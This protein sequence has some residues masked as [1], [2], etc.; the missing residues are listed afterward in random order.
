LPHAAAC[1]EQVL[2]THLPQSVL[3]NDGGGGAAA[4]V[5]SELGLLAADV[6]AAGAE[7]ADAEALGV[8]EPV[9]SAELAAEEV[10]AAGLSGGLDPPPHA[11]QASGAA[12]M[13]T[14][15]VIG[16]R[17]ARLMVFD[18]V[19]RSCKESKHEVWACRAGRVAAA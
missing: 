7:D 17:W 19:A 15:V 6:S 5:A 4:A 10:S 16:R 12:T 14:R 8:S 3:P 9:G 18:C 2:S 11:S 1:F 13:R